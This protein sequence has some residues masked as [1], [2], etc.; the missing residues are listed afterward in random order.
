MVVEKLIQELRELKTQVSEAILCKKE[1]LTLDEAAQY[2]R[3]S[4]S[5]LYKLNLI[6][7]IPHSKPAQKLIYYKRADLDAWMMK[8]YTESSVV[9]GQV[10]P[11]K[12]RMMKV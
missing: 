1:I 4:K 2:L 8:N 3:I 9:L 11:R 12:R 6:N 7:G 10:K 5:T